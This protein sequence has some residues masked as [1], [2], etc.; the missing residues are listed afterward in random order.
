VRGEPGA[1]ARGGAPL[2]GLVALDVD[3]TVLTPHGEVAPSTAAA[4]AAARAG[5][6]R[7]VLASSRGPVA[8]ERI[9][10]A[11]GLEGEWFIGFQGALVARR[12]G[13]GLEVLAEAP[14]E[15]AL[16]RQVE[17][18]AVEAGLS[19]GR[20]TGSRWRVP[21]LTGAIL[22]EAAG[23]GEEP[24][25]STPEEADADGPPHKLM[26]IAEGDAEEAALQRLA[27]A[28]PSGVTA[29]FSGA[30]CLE[31]TADAVDKGS[32]LVPLA[33]H[34]G[35]PAELTAAVGDGPNDLGIFRVVGHP[36]AMGQAAAE[37]R[38]AARWVT[39]SNTEDGVARALV[40]LGVA[41][42][43]APGGAPGVS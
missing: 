6:V 20:Y 36:V 42:G 40:A 27:A 43:G 4:V 39:S 19:V 12:R 17:A 9:Q 2:V 41:P 24:L 11:L 5:S 21:R 29:T 37:V 38:S 30:A 8:L 1:A 33:R 32:G 25:L 23:T 16:A 28:M 22:R 10:A 18:L 26:V 13:D 35:I 7:V 15:R 3:G 31:V 14:L 34:L